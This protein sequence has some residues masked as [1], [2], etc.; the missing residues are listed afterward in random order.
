MNVCAGICGSAS[1]G[2]N[3]AL[4]NFADRF[5]AT[6]IP[7]D[8]L[9]RLVA[10]SSI[11]LDTLPHSAGVITMLSTTKLTHK[12]AYINN[13]IL[14]LVLPIVMACFAALLISMGFYL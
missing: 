5:I 6:G 10:M 2:E 11:G 4:Q 9:H 7:A 14:S 1:S 3:I 8:Q 12:Q 13:F